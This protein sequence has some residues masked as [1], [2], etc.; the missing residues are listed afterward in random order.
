MNAAAGTIPPPSQTPKRPWVVAV[1]GGVASGKSLVRQILGA[2]GAAEIDA[3]KIA[4]EVLDDARV[5]EEIAH[6]LGRDVVTAE[7]TVD[8]SALARLVFGDSLEAQTGR[9][10]LE[11]IVHPRVRDRI[12][13]ELAR[14]TQENVPV[15]VLDVP[16]LLEVGWRDLADEVLFVAAPDE[17]RRARATSRGW[18]E[19]EWRQREKAQW[20]V[21]RKRAAADVVLDNGGSPVHLR[22]QLAQWWQ[23]KTGRGPLRQASVPP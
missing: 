6:T 11:A 1:V 18:R 20:P 21:E 5:A 16:L 17:V 13:E 22:K 14:V 2:W 8:R 19:A 23:E 10:K 7:G 9:R 3:D 4:H 12:R 15:V